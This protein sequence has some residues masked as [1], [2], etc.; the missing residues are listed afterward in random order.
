MLDADR[1][2]DVLSNATPDTTD[3]I[4]ARLRETAPVYWSRLFGGWVVT[5]YAH[6]LS[7]LR[8]PCFLTDDPIA[9]LDRFAVRGGPSLDNF[10][11]VMSTIPFIMDP[12]RH[13][14]V[15][16]FLSRVFKGLELAGLRVQIERYALELL[17]AAQKTGEIDLAVGYGRSLA[18][19]ALHRLLSIP[20]QDCYNL[21]AIA[22]QVIL[23][24]DPIPRRL[25]AIVD[26]DLQLGNLLEYF[27]RLIQ[28]RRRAPK[29][30]GLS[31]MI[32]LAERELGVDEVQLAGYCA[33]F[34]VAGEETT[35]TGISRASI[36]M[37]RQPE[38]RARLQVEP[39]RTPAAAREY[40]RLISPFQY[41]TR[42]AGKNIEIGDQQIRAGEIVNI[43]LAAANRD[44]SV[45]AN[46]DAFDLDRDDDAEAMPFGYGAYRC[47]GAGMAT[48]EIEAAISVL[49]RFGG[50]RLADD[51][52]KSEPRLRVPALATARAVF[53]DDAPRGDR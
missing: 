1:A 39:A 42:V 10:K 45:F 31:L 20:L 2:V 3:A 27:N 13:D 16:R 40:L 50:L 5:S 33:F 48:I 36:M 22:R 28:E 21:A 53:V 29:G 6:S 4:Y 18:L 14:D 24:F 17:L 34:F 9:R 11:A 43:V 32:G 35:A 41:V 38:I 8:N 15:R 46:P 19:F 49:A 7:I 47:L 26:A 30:D 44:P 37:A 12:P 51:N 25:S 52:P 23:Y